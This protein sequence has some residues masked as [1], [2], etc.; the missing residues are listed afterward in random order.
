[1]IQ[2]P[3][4]VEAPIIAAPRRPAL[5]RVSVWAMRLAIVASLAAIVMFVAYRV[6]PAL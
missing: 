4:P 1:M 2:M 6:L 3:A 5:A